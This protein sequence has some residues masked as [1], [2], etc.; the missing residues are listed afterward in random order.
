[1]KTNCFRFT[2]GLLVVVVASTTVFAADKPAPPKELEEIMVEV[3]LF[4]DHFRNE[5]WDEAKHDLEVIVKDYQA[6]KPQLAKFVSADVLAKFEDDIHHFE[7]DV[8]THN[9]KD[10]EAHLVEVQ[11]IVIDFMEH[12]NYKH[13]P[14]YMFMFRYLEEMEEELAHGKFDII[15]A[16][17]HEFEKHEEK[18]V[19]QFKKDHLPDA[20]IKEFIEVSHQVIKHAEA[21]DKTHVA[22]ELKRMEE[23]ILDAEKLEEVAH[24]H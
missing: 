13:A 6:I 24:A 1:M 7:E 18:L 8:K 2:L 3:I 12:F 23:I 11:H 4:E 5:H 9:L 14:I 10:V 15:V 17:M 22:A 19:K 21:H 20:E 16:E